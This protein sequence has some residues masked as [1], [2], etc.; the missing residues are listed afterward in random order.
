MQFNNSCKY[1]V[2]WLGYNPTTATVNQ[3][4]TISVDGQETEIATSTLPTNFS[5]TYLGEYNCK[6]YGQAILRAKTEKGKSSLLSLDYIK[7][8]PVIE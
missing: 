8:V 1:K 3:L 7:L 6:K 4:L 5:E 2:Y